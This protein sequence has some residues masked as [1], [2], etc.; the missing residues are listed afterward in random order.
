MLTFLCLWG[1]WSWGVEKGEVDVGGKST[2]LRAAPEAVAGRGRRGDLFSMWAAIGPGTCWV[3]G[4]L[5][6]LA[7]WGWGGDWCRQTRSCA[8]LREHVGLFVAVDIG[9][10]GDPADS[11]D[12]CLPQGGDEL[13]DVGDE[14]SVGFGLPLA[15]TNVEGILVVDE[16]V[17]VPRRASALGVGPG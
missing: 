2:G 15:N 11:E 5:A 10:P 6:A 4:V 9:V 12:C 17:K 8:L 16:Q 7:S 14:W 3:G 13:T 1:S